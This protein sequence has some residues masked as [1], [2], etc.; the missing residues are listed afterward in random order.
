MERRDEQSQPSSE[1]PE[2]YI[3]QEGVQGID[4]QVLDDLHGEGTTN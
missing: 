1:E 4:G 2:A 3:G